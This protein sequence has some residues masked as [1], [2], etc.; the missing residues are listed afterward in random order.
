M[1]VYGDRGGGVASTP[2]C[3]LPD[4]T[5]AELIIAQRVYSAVCLGR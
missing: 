2:G 4:V 1:C 5:Y 3:V